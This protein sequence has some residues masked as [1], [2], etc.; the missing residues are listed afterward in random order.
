MPLMLSLYIQLCGPIELPAVLGW[1][2]LTGRAAGHPRL[3]PP[4]G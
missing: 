3:G 4:S 1:W 2:A